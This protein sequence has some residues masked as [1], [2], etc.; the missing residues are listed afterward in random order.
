MHAH[1]GEL[2]P[3]MTV[4]NCHQFRITRNSDLWVDEEEMENLLQ[5]LQ[6]ELP[7]RRF[8]DAV[9][10]E[11]ADDMPDDLVELLLDHAK[12]GREDLYRV[13]GAVNLHRL[14]AIYDDV[15]RDDLK[16]EPFVP[17]LQA[18]LRGEEPIFEVL[19][20]GDVL[21]HH[22]FQSFAP[23]VELVRQAARDPNVMAIKQTLYRTDSGS[24]LVEA[25]IEAAQAGKDVTALV[26]LRARFDEQA[27]IQIASRL[28]AVGANVVYG[29]VGYKT[30]A[31]MLLIVRR[32]GK[33]LR[34]YVHLGTGNYHAK[35]ATAYTDVGL[36]TASASFGEDVQALFD[37]L[38]GL[39]RATRMNRL[40]QSPFTLHKTLIELIGREIDEAKA[41]RPARIVARMNSLSELS[42]IRALYEASQAGVQV[43]LI[44]RGICCL[45]PGVPGLSENIRVRSIV[46]RFLEHSRVCHFHAA[47]EELTYCSSA[48]W[49]SRNLFRRVETCFPI[50]DPRLRQRVVQ[51][52]LEIYLQDNTQ[53]WELQSDG[54]Y[55]RVQPKSPG[56]R[57]SAQETLLDRHTG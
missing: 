4:E 29:I 14:A 25:L 6:G 43:D 12:L 13:S 5:A 27:N 54:S 48:D 31:K 11:V 1:V 53:S 40:L 41:G 45:R 44:V 33:K 39:G 20:R 9:R 35:T 15:E 46:G 56:D 16:Y 8:S 52:T 26:E 36:M 22:P 17:G 57:V 50:K 47:G 7:R 37:Q 49:M 42:T 21:L 18:R 55:V 19:Q 30:H 23:V 34:R 38:T 32:E 3:G 2:F 28:Q 10:L 51:E 24:P